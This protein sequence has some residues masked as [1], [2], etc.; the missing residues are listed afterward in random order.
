MNMPEKRS[1]EVGAAHREPLVQVHQPFPMLQP[2]NEVNMRCCSKKRPEG[3]WK[4]RQANG[5]RARRQNQIS[6]KEV[7][8]DRWENVCSERL[9]CEGS[10]GLRRGDEVI[11]PVRVRTCGQVD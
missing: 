6:S 10:P 2:I 4:E 5:Q 11:Y 3:Y 8:S 1:K 7:K 9:P